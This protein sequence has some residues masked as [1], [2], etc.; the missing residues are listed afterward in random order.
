VRREVAEPGPW[1]AGAGFLFLLGAALLALV[2]ATIPARTLS[3][4]SMRLVERRQD[5]GLA[6]ALTLAA[7]AAIF[8][9]LVGA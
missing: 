1:A 4:I 8:I 6:M 3:A 2:F 9:I 7:S 5:I